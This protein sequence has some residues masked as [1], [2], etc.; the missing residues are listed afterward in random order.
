MNFMIHDWCKLTSEKHGKTLT[1]VPRKE[2][3]E[4][5]DDDEA[6]AG[7]FQSRLFGSQNLC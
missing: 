1:I 5:E 3:S 4:E 7:E 2:E 6:E